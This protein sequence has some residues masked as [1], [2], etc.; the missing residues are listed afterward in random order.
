MKKILLAIA[1]SILVSCGGGS[2]S[3]SPT[4]VA[5]ASFTASVQT[6]SPVIV[7]D[8]I[9]AYTVKT[10]D[11]SFAKL[12]EKQQW[13]SF[14]KPFNDKNFYITPHLWNHQNLDITVTMQGCVK[15]KVATVK[16]DF[17][18]ECCK[19]GSHASPHVSYGWD[20]TLY[21]FYNSVFYYMGGDNKPTSPFPMRFDSMPKKLILDYDVEV[22][23]LNGWWHLTSGLWAYPLKTDR[24]WDLGYPQPM[25]IH[26]FGTE[27]MKQGLSNTFDRILTDYQG[28]LWGLRKDKYWDCD[29]GC[30]GYEYSIFIQLLNGSLKERIDLVPV[31]QYVNDLG[32]IK[33]NYGLKNLNIGTEI[34]HGKNTVN[35]KRFSV[36][37]E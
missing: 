13:L 23:N 6:I 32:W 11:E 33:S 5:K 28:K 21:H 29:G 20:D 27:E 16:Y 17:D 12:T 14:A 4:S 37:V 26:F 19:P 8:C 9:N 15:D 36:T 34:L 35:I 2:G 10:K 7:D 24:T 18:V 22:A 31:L 1:S 3:D 25:D 30:T